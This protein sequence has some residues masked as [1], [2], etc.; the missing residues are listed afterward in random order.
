MIKFTGSLSTE[1]R[2]I[3]IDNAFFNFFSEI[4]L[5]SEAAKKVFFLVFL[6]VRTLRGGAVTGKGH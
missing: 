2:I 3:S 6:V 4:Y 5:L 1:Y